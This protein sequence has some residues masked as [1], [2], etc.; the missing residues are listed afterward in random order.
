MRLYGPVSEWAFTRSCSRKGG[1]VGKRQQCHIV[2]K[3]ATNKVN[4]EPPVIEIRDVEE[5]RYDPEYAHRITAEDER[6]GMVLPIEG[7]LTL[8]RVCYISRG[9]PFRNQFGNANPLSSPLIDQ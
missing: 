9:L 2:W 8:L 7:L 3:N 6:T 1:D 4:N 5:G